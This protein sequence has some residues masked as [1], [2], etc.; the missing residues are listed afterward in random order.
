MRIFMHTLMCLARDVRMLAF[1]GAAVC[2]LLILAAL[3]FQHG[4]GLEP[5]PLCILQRIAFIKAGVLFLLI[6][7]FARRNI[8]RRVLAALGMLNNFLGA[9]VAA[10]HVWLQSL[11]A[12]QV[13]ECGPGL[14]YLLDAFP[15]QRALS[16]ILRGSGEC[17]EVQ[18]QLI[19]LSMPGWSLLWLLVLFALFAHLLLRRV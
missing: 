10:R 5:C 6:G 3:Y 14:G 19:G 7:I 2:A 17:A 4:A 8:A 12:G 9:A 11:P 18:W 1:G 16:L 15:L 13:P